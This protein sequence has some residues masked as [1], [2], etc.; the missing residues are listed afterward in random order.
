MQLDESGALKQDRGLIR[1]NLIEVSGKAT[2][3]QRE[4]ERKGTAWRSEGA[5]RIQT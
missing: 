3:A 2:H 1:F 4:N 5:A